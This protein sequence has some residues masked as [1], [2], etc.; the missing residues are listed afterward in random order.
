MSIVSQEVEL[1]NI[2][3]RDTISLGRTIS[4]QQ[5]LEVIN[6]LKLAEWY[7]QLPDGL[8]TMV[9]EKGIKLSAGQK[10]RINI[11]RGILLDRQITLFDE[12]TSHLDQETEKHVVEFLKDQLGNRSAIFI[13]HRPAVE[14][15]CNRKFIFQSS[16]LSEVKSDE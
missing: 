12:P 14:A 5:I 6:G 8:D 7:E 10:Q 1:F 4:D 2:T 13:S 11:A 16:T 15:L 9:G 3:V